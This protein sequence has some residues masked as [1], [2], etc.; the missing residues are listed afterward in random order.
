MGC[1]Q[2]MNQEKKG[3]VLAHPESKYRAWS[4]LDKSSLLRQYELKMIGGNSLIQCQFLGTISFFI[5]VH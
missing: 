2:E 5:S 4:G 3:N 1:C